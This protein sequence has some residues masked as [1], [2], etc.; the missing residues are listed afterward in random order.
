MVVPK[1]AVLP[2]VVHGF[3][4]TTAL[5]D[6]WVRKVSGVFNNVTRRTKLDVGK[7][8]SFVR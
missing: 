2:S 8:I 1:V 6:W 4:T 7:E 3:V 5:V